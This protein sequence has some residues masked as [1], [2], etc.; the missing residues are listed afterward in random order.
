MQNASE[1]ITNLMASLENYYDAA[2]NAML[3]KKAVKKYGKTQSIV[4]LI[5]QEG[6]AA[7]QSFSMEGFWE[8]VKNFLLS[9]WEKIKEWW[10][11]F[12]GMFFSVESKLSTFASDCKSSSKRLAHNVEFDAPD[13]R[14]VLATSAIA[15]EGLKEL[16]KASSGV[17]DSN[18]L[19]RLQNMAGEFDTRQHGATV[20]DG[21]GFSTMHYNINNVKECGNIAKELN[22]KVIKKFKDSKRD[23]DDYTKKF[24]DK[25]KNMKVSAANAGRAG[26]IYGAGAAPAEKREANVS[27]QDLGVKIIKQA[28]KINNKC[29]AACVKGA[30]QI[31]VKLMAHTRL[32]D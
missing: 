31:A 6:L 25:I 17:A 22:D 32:V 16:K 21:T 11:R 3:V 14:A 9:I 19:S 30:T 7:A 28:A 20:K 23:I 8:K 15:E 2:R 13:Y 12:W 1:A 29:I 27:E 10:G 18:V 26:D 24:I 4:A 5:G